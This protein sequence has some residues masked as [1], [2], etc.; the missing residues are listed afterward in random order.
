MEYNKTVA[1]LESGDNIEGF[2]ILKNTSIRTSNAGKPYLC[3]ALID[4]T[5]EIETRAWDYAGPISASDEGSVV[6]IRGTV[7][8]YRG[9]RQLIIDKIRLAEDRD[10]YDFSALVPVAPI[11]REAAWDELK[12]V[13]DEMPD[14]DYQRI[15]RW[16][17]ERYGE[18]FRVL[19]GG[20]SI[21]HAFIG[22]LLMH[23]V[24]MVRI[25]EKM[26]EMYGDVVDRDLLVTGTLLH[27]WAKCGEF[28]VLSLGLVTDYSKK[29]KLLGHLVMGAQ[30]VAQAAREVGA[31][32]EKSLLLQHMLLSHHGEPEFGAAVRPVCAES[33]LLYMIDLLDSRM[34]IYREA[35]AE[36]ESGTFS[37]KIFALGKQIYRH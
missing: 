10:V 11:D 2:Y 4:K 35:L 24:N 14:K 32:E 36:M 6:K 17:M 15:I 33:E 22:G 26:V 12:R 19:P 9:M 20:K 23:T 30:A 34:E 37:Q 31:P 8:E 1:S 3:T 13:A 28:A 7:S 21:H 27:D 5:G 16:M 25:A 18:Q 29:G